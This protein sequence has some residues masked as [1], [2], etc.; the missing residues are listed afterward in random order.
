[1][2]LLFRRHGD[3]GAAFLDGGRH[4]VD[5]FPLQYFNKEGTAAADRFGAERRIIF[6]DRFLVVEETLHTAGRGRA[7]Y[8]WW[9][10][11]H[12]DGG[13]KT[14][15]RAVELHAGGDVA[16]DK[17]GVSFW[18]FMV[19]PF[20]AEGE[21][22]LYCGGRD[23]HRGCVFATPLSTLLAKGTQVGPPDCLWRRQRKGGRAG[24]A[25]YGEED[26]MGVKIGLI[27]LGVEQ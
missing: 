10:L 7:E 26:S 24:P 19:S 17:I 11:G 18:N 9:L 22:G 2:K 23:A 4:L 27:P 15:D 3:L 13:L 21:R 20:F 25:R 6:G 8:E 16:D 12:G 14:Q 5:S 1:M